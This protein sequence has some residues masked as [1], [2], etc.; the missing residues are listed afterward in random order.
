MFR[1]TSDTVNI[2]NVIL[3]LKGRNEDV[4]ALLVNAVL[5][6][7][8]FLSNLHIDA[9]LSHSYPV[10]LSG[11]LLS[12]DFVIKSIEVRAVWWPQGNFFDEIFTIPG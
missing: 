6:N 5:N 9:A 11:R 8:L 4:Y 10:L 2:Q 12:P 1:L 3:W 7:A